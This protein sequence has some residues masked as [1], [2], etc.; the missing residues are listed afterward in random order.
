VASFHWPGLE[1][2]A[3]TAVKFNEEKADALGYES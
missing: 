2:A 3:S 1:I